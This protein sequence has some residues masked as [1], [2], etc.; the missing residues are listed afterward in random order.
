MHEVK[1]FLRLFIAAALIANAVVL[2]LKWHDPIPQVS[3]LESRARFQTVRN[4]ISFQPNGPAPQ[5]PSE[6]YQLIRYSSR[7][8]DLAAY[9]TPDPKDGIKRPAV[10]WAHSG[11]GGIKD[12]SWDPEDD[13]SPRAFLNNNFVVM[14]PSWRHENDNPGAFE[15]FLGEVDDLLSAV[16]HVRKLSYVDPDRVYI[17]GYSI[18]GTLALLAAESTNTFRA[19]FCIG[20]T[21]DVARM[22][23][24]GKGDGPVPF[25]P[26]NPA[27]IEVRN[28]IR[29][30][31][32]LQIPTFYFEGGNSWEAPAACK[33]ALIAKENGRPFHNIIVPGAHHWSILQPACALI[34]TKI[35]Q[36]TGSRC[37]IDITLQ[38]T[39]KI[40]ATMPQPQQVFD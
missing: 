30:V 6:V 31:N 12:C 24:D 20:G 9:L 34:A 15:L 28:P 39:R 11:F 1:T 37:E 8:G 3:L 5:P 27:E 38:E 22:L 25:D 35:L 16:D 7:A 17:V 33:M 18:G 19:A 13:Q 29:F 32:A 26:R 2:A 23:A 21:T 10:V 40:Y 4:D 36:D 14:S